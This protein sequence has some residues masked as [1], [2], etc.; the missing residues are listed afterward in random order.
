MSVLCPNCARYVADG[1]FCPFCGH[2]LSRHAEKFSHA[3]KPGAVVGERFIVGEVLGRGE[4]GV[5]YSGFDNRANSRVIII[6]YLPEGSAKRDSGGSTLIPSSSEAA[7]VFEAGKAEFMEDATSLSELGEGEIHAAILDRFEQNGTAYC[8]SEYPGSVDPGEYV[9]HAFYPEKAEPADAEDVPIA[10]VVEV[11]DPEPAPAWTPQNDYPEA[12]AYNITP[13]KP[14]KKKPPLL[15]IGIAA[16]VLVVILIVALT[17]GGGKK[18]KKDKGAASSPSPAVTAAQ[19]GKNSSQK[20]S[21]PSAGGSAAPAEEPES[22]PEPTEEPAASPLLSLA[23]S[24]ELTR[25]LI[26]GTDFSDDLE[27]F[28]YLDMLP[29]LEI[30]GNNNGTLNLMDEI[31][32]LR[33][34]TG[35]MTVTSVK[36]D[37]SVPFTLKDGVIGFTLIANEM[38]FSPAGTA[39][40]AAGSAADTAADED[41]AADA[42]SLAFGSYRYNAGLWNTPALEPESPI[43]NC[44]GFTL[45]FR[46]DMVDT[47]TLGQ[48]R[49]YICINK[50]NTAWVESNRVN[51]PE[52]GVVYKT[53]I[54]LDKPRS[55]E[56]ITLLPVKASERS[57]RVTAWI[58]NIKYG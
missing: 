55:I 13:Q 37:T 44:V 25:W 18:D 3:L 30:D 57:F 45:C 39:K 46:Y 20:P 21:K 43:E 8:I 58:E 53:D 2:D 4:F 42:V 34:D 24:Y 51:I 15:W 11:P 22:S 19:D 56:A 29:T 17:A 14:A 48:H 7:A 54:R 52:E 47:S 50:K 38:E 5:T 26:G 31:Y 28:A 49:V 27:T 40:P 6:E 33:F 1:K 23:G 35:K 10:A 12:A 41:R 36:D 32:D 16:A 9:P